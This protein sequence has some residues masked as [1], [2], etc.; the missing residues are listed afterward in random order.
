M[1]E[2]MNEWM[3]EYRTVDLTLRYDRTVSFWSR[4]IPSAVYCMGFM[5]CLNR[6]MDVH[7]HNEWKTFKVFSL[8]TQTAVSYTVKDFYIIH[9]ELY[10]LFESNDLK[11]IFT[12]FQASLK[13]SQQ[14]WRTALLLVLKCCI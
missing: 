4:Y 11:Q 5:S 7:Q 10:I 8:K 9:T 1:N 2:W 6:V 13:E 12:R 14:F 3:N